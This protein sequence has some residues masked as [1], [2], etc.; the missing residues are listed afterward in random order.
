MFV[1]VLVV[2]CFLKVREITANT[3]SVDVADIRC[4]GLLQP[5]VKDIKIPVVTLNGLEGDHPFLEMI[6]DVDADTL[7]HIG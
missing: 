2:L 1:K 5:T 3:G 4:L 6:A 7:I